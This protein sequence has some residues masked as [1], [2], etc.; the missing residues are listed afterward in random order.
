MSTDWMNRPLVKRPLPLCLK[1]WLRRGSFNNFITLFHH[2]TVPESCNIYSNICMCFSK[3]H[4]NSSTTITIHKS[5]PF[6]LAVHSLLCLPA[7][8]YLSLSWCLQFSACL[9]SP[10]SVCYPAD[11]TNTSY[12]N[13]KQTPNPIDKTLISRLLVCVCVSLIVIM[14]LFSW[15]N[16]RWKHV[17]RILSANQKIKKRTLSSLDCFLS[18]S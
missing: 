5:L 17:S 18:Y 1:S 7:L 14:I 2:E 8:P 6:Y 12:G 16:F 3:P 15:F 9:I 10:S 11:C 4:P 13:G